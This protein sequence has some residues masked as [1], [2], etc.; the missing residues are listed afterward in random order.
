MRTLQVA[1]GE[2]SYP[3]HIGAGLLGRADL[4]APHV[5]GRRVLLVTNEVVA[6]LYAEPT[7]QALRQHAAHVHTLVLADGEAH[8]TLAT[9]AGIIDAMVDA[10]LGRDGCVVALGGGVTGDMAGFAAACYQRGVDWVQLPTT[11][12]AQVDSSV[13]GKTGVNHAAGKN[14]IG[15]FHQ[16]V[17]V[18]C[19][20][21]TLAT[22][23][24]RHYRAG[25]AEVIKYGL[26][27]D[28]TFFAWLEAN[29]AAL[30]GRDEATLEYAVERCCA[31]KAEVVAG[32][33]RERSGLRALLNLGHTFGHGI[34][35]AMGYG[36]WLHGEAVAAGMVMASDMSRR[37]G[38]TGDADHARVAA[39][40][41]AAG[42]PVS[43]PSIGGEAL[44]EHM[45]FDKKSRGGRLNLVL[46]KALGEA[47]VSGD[48]PDEALAA[49]LA[50]ADAPG[51]APTPGAAAA[52]AGAGGD[53]A[54]R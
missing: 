14:L 30:L 39:L 40:V 48:F 36:G 4:L 22:L 31:I 21:A 10:G 42:L 16:P 2:R 26:I 5:H 38:W 34:E 41:G 24:P 43:P 52:D 12:L 9:A 23:D 54:E 28:A 44:L 17:A 15:A 7:A 47:T 19:D 13:G 11:L 18:L 33:E 45:R 6:P 49:T 53:G 35:R 27:V 3:I 25:L 29:M 1:L 8:K 20:L 46:L 50:A 51:A 37:L 32:D